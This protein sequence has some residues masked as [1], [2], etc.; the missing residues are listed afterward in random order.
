MT[1]F[2]FRGA[3][4]GLLSGGLAACAM[5]PSYPTAA[6]EAA[7]AGVA[8][9]PPTPPAAV[10]PPPPPP[11]AT[12]SAPPSSV[13][14]QPLAPAAPPANTPP[15][16]ASAPRPPVTMSPPPDQGRPGGGGQEVRAPAEAPRYAATGN[17]VEAHRMFRDYVV[18][19]G[20]HLDAIARD[21]DTTRATLLE[22]NHLKKPNDLRPG[23]HLKVPIERAYVV[24]SGD[25]VAVVARRFGVSAADLADLNAI[26][27]NERLRPGEELA[28]P[29]SYHDRGPV[30][31][32]P[33]RAYANYAPPARAYGH[34]SYTPAPWTPPAGPRPAGPYPSVA[35]EAPPTR[36]DS[37]VMA[38]GKGRFV[39]PVRGQILSAFGVQ[40]VD[41][42]ND[43]VDIKSPMGTSVHAA[44]A[45]EVVYA[46]DQVP[47]FGNLVL[48]KHADGWVTAYAHL[49]RVDV[50][51]RE[52]VAQDQEIG[53]VGQ[54]GGVNE[55]QL[56]F[57]VRYAA[58]PIEKARP[59]DPLL[60]LPE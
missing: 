52:T 43:G 35:T 26:S 42:R 36:T 31:L 5:T 4:L 15:P 23:Q 53:E 13:E 50:K 18:R 49:A 14:S 34:N 10:P 19:K 44:A 17:V 40:D 56:H 29:A 3:V 47:G 9:A 33:A 8:P 54:T 60:V 21:L 30:L 59:V 6:P 11:E 24:A 12:P 58:T 45:G 38:A 46:G 25:T 27:E 22:A 32:P 57:E 48:V 7:P 28:L 16:S 55:P 37:Q 20:D 51:M 41:R 39:W 2:L 1:D